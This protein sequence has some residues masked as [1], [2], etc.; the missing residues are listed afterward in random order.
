MDRAAFS[1]VM[2]LG[3][4]VDSNDLGSQYHQKVTSI[5]IPDL[6]LRLLIS[7]KQERSP[8]LEAAAFE[9]HV[10]LDIY[11]APRHHRSHTG[12]QIS[13]ILEQDRPS[14]RARRM[15]G[16]Y[17]HSADGNQI[18][19]CESSKAH[20]HLNKVFIPLPTIPD[21]A[22]RSQSNREFKPFK[23]TRSY[24]SGTKLAEASDS[25]AETGISEAERDARLA[26]DGPVHIQDSVT[27][28]FIVRLVAQ[29]R[30]HGQ[31]LKKRP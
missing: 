9:T 24:V 21:L 11:S 16:Q 8:W 27:E 6:V 10:S 29:H 5:R 30:F 13:F 1:V 15:F 12:K 14:G 23:K 26:Y 25:D 18:L 17:L 7:G 3:L 2:P 22:R 20:S 19:D 28:V 4:K 31:S